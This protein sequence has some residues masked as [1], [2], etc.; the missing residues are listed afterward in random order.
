MTKQIIIALA[1]RKGGVGKTTLALAV[2]SV[3]AK[4]RRTLLID[5]DPDG[6]A[7]FGLGADVNL[8][9]AGVLLSGDKPAFQKISDTLDLV[10]G[11]QDLE[12]PQIVRLEPE[13]LG[14]AIAKLDYE[15]I[16]IDSPATA[17]NLQKFGVVAA[18]KVL[19]PM[20]AHPFAI[21]RAR[22]LLDELGRRRDSG[23]Q[24]AQAWA[25]VANQIDER[26]S[27]DREFVGYI[28][29]EFKGIPV[30]SIHQDTFFSRAT[31]A[32][33][34]CTG[35]AGADESLSEID[36]IVKWLVN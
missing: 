11:N 22:A 9:G 27:L 30:F 4:K 26:R 36:R 16:V 21:K 33:M 28:R 20:N 2:A 31:T 23:R 15:A 1:T 29:G 12:D 13:A 32:Q 5:L 10:G 3:L 6:D 8:P 35:F 34:P 19:V 14:D 18:Q 17:H 24:G 25:L 7:T